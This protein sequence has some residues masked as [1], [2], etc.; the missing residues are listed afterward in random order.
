MTDIPT[1]AVVHVGDHW[2]FKAFW[3]D[4]Q[5]TARLEASSGHDQLVV[6]E[7][8]FS[9]RERPAEWFIEIGLDDLLAD[10]IWQV[11]EL[12]AQ[13]EMQATFWTHKTR[14]GQVTSDSL[15]REVVELRLTHS[16]AEIA[17]RLGRSRSQIFRYLQLA[18]ERGLGDPE[19]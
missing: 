6:T 3:P 4:A 14:R 10:A 17:E 15:L 12:E 2:L 18:R 5:L 19:M 8:S 16:A 1:K 13:P 11:G 7:L 9:P